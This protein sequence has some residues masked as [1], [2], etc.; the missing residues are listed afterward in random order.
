[1]EREKLIEILNFITTVECSDEQKKALLEMAANT[2]T[3]DKLSELVGNNDGK[4]TDQNK[5]SESSEVG[6]VKFT[7]KEISRMPTYFRKT[8]RTAGCN[9]HVL[10]RKSG[11]NS[12]N[13]MIRYRRNGYNIVVSSNNLEEAKRKFIEKLHTADQLKKQQEF[14]KVTGTPI[15]PSPLLKQQTEINGVPTTFNK[16]ANYYLEKF[17]KR[18]VCEETYRVTLSN[19][20]NHVLPHFGDMPLTSITADKCQELLDKLIAEDKVRTEENVFSMLNMLFKAAVKHTVMK[21]NPMDMVFHTKHEREHG[22]ALTKDEEKLLLSSTE[23]TPYQQMF[24]IGLYTGFRPNEYKTAYIE[25]GFIVANNSKRKNG[26]VELKKIP[27]TPM[28]APYVKEGDSLSFYR[29][30]QIRHK[31]NGILPSHKLYDLRTTFYTRC[32]ECGVAEAAIKKYVGHTLGGLADTYADLGDDFLR[33]EGQKL[34]Y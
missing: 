24:A 14:A 33:R 10:R 27:I 17:H 15:T 7:K 1:M 18:K 22:K 20:K 6:I 25:D 16:F 21:H 2:I 5:A 23:G 13:Y 30:E 32:M 28:L 34:C 8:F 9:A 11:K 19:F 31:F 3:V 4:E 29:L 12:W 26:K